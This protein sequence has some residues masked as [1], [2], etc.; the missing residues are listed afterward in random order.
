MFGEQD[1]EL[2]YIERAPKKRRRSGK[3]GVVPRG[4]DIEVVELMH[5]THMGV[6]QEYKN[7]IKQCTRCA[8]SDGWAAP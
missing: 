1:G 2:T 7:I 4:C 6:D 3:Q 8:L 5:R